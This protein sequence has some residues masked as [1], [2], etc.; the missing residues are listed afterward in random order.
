MNIRQRAFAVLAGAALAH[1][2][3]RGQSAD[4][5]TFNPLSSKTGGVHLLGVSV[6]TSYFSN[7]YGVGLTGLLPTADSNV[8][9]AQGSLLLGWSRQRQKSNI[10]ITYSPSYVHGIQLSYSSFNQAFSFAAAKTLNGKW[11]I[12]SS[13]QVLLSDFT[14]LLFSPTRYGSLSAEPSTFD[15]LSAAM[16]T[17]RSDNTSLQQ[18]VGAASAISSPETAAVY[19]NRLLSA[20]AVVSAS[21]AQSTRSTYHVSAL[22]SRAQYYT[23]GS[24]APEV[25][26][27]YL[28]PKTTTVE[29]LLGWSY[30]LTPRTNLSL[31]GSS[32]RTVSQY[33]DG[34]LSQANVSLGRTMS[35]RWFV[36]G[37]VGVGYI[38]PTRQTISTP[39]GAQEQYGGSIGY[40]LD[41]HTLLA[42]YQ[43]T[44]Y[45]IYGF[46]ASAME[47]STGAWTW[48]RPGRTVS[49]SGS[50]GYIRLLGSP[51]P[52]QGS[53]TAHVV[54]VKALNAH[55]AVSGGYSYVQ[56]PQTVLVSAPNLTQHGVIVTLSWSPSERQ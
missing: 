49:V 22:A 23:G 20:A 50:F 10:N 51:F 42:S 35:R 29:A 37:M 11:S 54:A 8:V 39:R 16:L 24:S 6:S 30:S 14:Q 5:E 13:V 27:G 34:Y 26:P 15:D 45:D 1:C 32:T 47:T 9:I 31:D 55:L 46:G 21:Y 25:R 40:K 2:A 48:K 53:W 18:L 3:A 7:A 56:Y 52:N 38:T 28:I 41:A 43:R 17:G 36:Q 4:F 44:A 33:Q 19:G 12:D